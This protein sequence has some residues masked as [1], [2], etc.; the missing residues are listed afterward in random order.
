MAVS[1]GKNQIEPSGIKF[2]VA[3]AFFGVV[4]GYSLYTVLRFSW[5][6]AAILVVAFILLM[7]SLDSYRIWMLLF[8]T[9]TLSAFRFDVAEYITLRPEHF[10]FIALAAGLL[11]SFLAGKARTSKVPFLLPLA[12]FIGVNYLSTFINAVDLASSLRNAVLL[13]LFALMY[14]FT[15]FVI[16]ANPEKGTTII[17]FFL[18]LAVLQSVFAITEQA[19][20]FL[21]LDLGVHTPPVDEGSRVIRSSGGFQEANLLGAFVAAA[22]LILVALMASKE[23]FF[24]GNFYPLLALVTIIVTLIFTYTRTAWIGFMVGMFLLLFMQRS[25][26]DIVNKRVGSIL[27]YAFVIGLI[28]FVF[29]IGAGV[30]GVVDPVF[31]RSQELLDFSGGSGAGRAEVQEVA[32]DKWRR[33]AILLG[34]GT[35]SLPWEEALPSPAG[36]WLYSSFVQAL[37]DT[38]LVGLALIVWFQTG[39]LLFLV[40]SYGRVVDVV[41]RSVIAGCIVAIIALYIA[42]QAS[43]FIWLGFPWVFTG[44]AVAYAQNA[45]NGA[46]VIR[47]A[48]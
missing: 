32:L 17:W 11:L 48:Q 18:V 26:S 3:S 19:L 7:L 1:D 25:G 8:A 15:I 28:A 2:A 44:F 23:K 16:R 34:H 45:V 37:H 14:V 35:M 21:G 29:M 12:L 36:P 6:Y 42:S 20:Y 24:K 38:G 5:L 46:K 40:R 41:S 10:V 47:A 30:S 4:I 43:S 22:G 31:N 13:T 33:D 39:V 9:T 27:L